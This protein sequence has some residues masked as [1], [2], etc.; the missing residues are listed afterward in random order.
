[1]RDAQC[2]N[3]PGVLNRSGTRALVALCNATE[4][5]F[6]PPRH[7][8]ASELLDAALG[9]GGHAP[10]H[11]SARVLGVPARVTHRRPDGLVHLGPLPLQRR[12]QAADPEVHLRGGGGGR[13]RTRVGR[14]G[15]VSDEK[16]RLRGAGV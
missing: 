14:C 3:M 16:R 13:R 15:G 4:P 8:Q 9:H 6:R 2:T 12:A 1:V 5:S 11:L 7:L 10:A